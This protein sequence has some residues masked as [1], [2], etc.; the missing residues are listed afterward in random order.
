MINQ[1]NSQEQ[2]TRRVTI[3][4]NGAHIFVPKEWLNENV[5]ILRKQKKPLKEKILNAIEPYLDNIIGAYLY[6]SQARNE[7]EE[8]SDIDLLLITNKPLKIKENEFEIL[9]LSINE[10]ERAIETSSEMV[11]SILAE[12]KPI[13]NS[14]LLEELKQKYKPDIKNFSK[15]VY[16]TKKI[17]KINQNALNEEAKLGEE[18][19]DDSSAYSL[20]LRLKGI[21]IIKC[22]LN[23]KSFSNKEFKKWLKNNIKNID[24]NTI[25]EAYKSVKNNSKAKQ[26]IKIKDLISLLELLT[27]ETNNLEKKQ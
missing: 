6:G 7:A 5:I 2:I 27:K 17:I 15:F 8:D 20:I 10:I 19:D 9:C 4:G 21:F 12:A 11:Y 25:Y 18:T 23:N 24:Y 14:S 22:L 26:K 16:S 13:I 3:I 1:L